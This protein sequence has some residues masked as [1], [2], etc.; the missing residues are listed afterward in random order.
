MT[1]WHRRFRHNWS[2][3]RCSECKVAIQGS[4]PPH[5]TDNIAEQCTYHRATQLV[6]QEIIREVWIPLCGEENRAV[7]H[8]EVT[9]NCEQRNK[10]FSRRPRILHRISPSYNVKSRR[11]NVCSSIATETKVY[12]INRIWYSNT[13]FT[14]WVAS[15]RWFWCKWCFRCS[16][17]CLFCRYY[18]NTLCSALHRIFPWHNRNIQTEGTSSIRSGGRTHPENSTLYVTWYSINMDNDRIMLASPISPNPASSPT[19]T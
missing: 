13:G 2:I 7:R 4:I 11:E 15:C 14:L 5:R 1:I 10:I 19:D 8:K 17:S 16:C 18:V 6:L 3:L 9:Q 12:D